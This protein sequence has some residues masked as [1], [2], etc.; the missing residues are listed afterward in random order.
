MRNG[1]DRAC[2]DCSVWKRLP[3]AAN[4]LLGRSCVEVIVFVGL[5]SLTVPHML[6]ETLVARFHPETLPSSTRGSAARSLEPVV[7][8]VA[9]RSICEGRLHTH[10]EN[11][12]QIE[13]QLS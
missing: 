13:R 11:L 12:P 1:P 6:L 8:S 9:K 5:A 4:C 7:G 3:P 10:E 2:D